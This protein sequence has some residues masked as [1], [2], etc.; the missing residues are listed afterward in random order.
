MQ[1]GLSVLKMEKLKAVRRMRRVKNKKVI[2]R[3]ADRTRQAGKSRNLIA[4]LAIALTAVLFTSVF[5][6]GGSLVN[7]Q[8]QETMRQVG[9]SAQAG[10]KYLTEEEYNIVKQDKKLKEI[11]YRIVVGDA[12]NRELNKLHTE[13]SYYEEL[14]AKFSFCYPEVGRLPEKRDEIVTSDLVLKA[15]GLPCKIGTKVPVTIRIGNKERKEVFTLSGYFKG[16]TIFQAQIMAVS[17]IFANEVAPTP[18]NSAMEKMID[19][20]DYPGRIMA[21]FN[22]RSSFGLKWQ[23]QQLVKRCGFP[24]NIDTGL[25]WAYVGGEI[26][27]EMIVFLGVILLVILV[28]GYLIIYNIFYINVFQDIRYYGILKTIGTTGKQLKKIVRRQ[29]YM[30]SLYGIPLGLLCGVTVGKCILPLI[31][32]QLSFSGTIDTEVSLNI[33]VFI[34]SAAFSFL[35]VYVSCI[36]PCRIA[37]KVSPI[38]AI[39]FT[40]GQEDVGKKRKG[41]KTK[42]VSPGEMALQNIKRNKKKVVIV[43]SSL[44]LALVLLNSIYGLVSGFDMDKYV[45]NMTVSD[46]SVADATVDNVSVFS[47]AKILDGVTK[48]FLEELPKREGVEETGNIYLKELISTF[49]DEDF[50]KIE[51]RILDNPEAEP[52]FRD[53]LGEETDGY[54]TMMKEERWIDGKVYGIGKMIADKLDNLE[55]QIDWK[56]F[57][58]GKYVITGHFGNTEDGNISYF[59]PG[60]TVTLY[61]EKGESREYEVLAEADMPYAC[62]LQSFGV[63][64]CNYI[65]PETEYLDFMGKTQPMRTLFNVK[66]K[67]EKAMEEWMADYCE[68]VNPDLDYTSKMQIVKEF[69]SNKN[70]YTMVGG[71]LA[72]ILAMIGILNFI[73]TMIT[74]VLSRK[75]EFA[76]ME[77]VGMT[78]RQLRSML[79]CEGACY[80]FFTLAVSL[81]LGVIMETTVIRSIGN[82]Y[83]Y[84]TWHLT[85]IPILICIP[86]L[87]MVVFAVPVFCHKNMRRIS[88]VERMRKSE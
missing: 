19:A 33:G 71:L 34:F 65:L 12:I 74:S 77:A 27:T 73:N 84:F 11:S 52:H 15:L 16:D 68:N 47:E 80:A 4:V 13:V 31:M 40:E 57:V 64:E 17:K 60:E 59:K 42:R 8:Q 81:I 55:G 49:T 10:F 36:K 50:S 54:V 86:V 72:F 7:K 85:V 24:D 35:T 41:K 29:A 26:D 39:R 3:I 18:K 5:T 2:R 88:V 22:F 37:S 63:M 53:L 76:M 45:S 30:L 69:E 51:K 78:G 14:D 62:G 28:S 87:C 75:Q 61:N 83:F 70:M 46:F 56:K 20:T 79:C 32:E 82:S 25:N 66:E 21:D 48:D 6:V 9:G 1:T 58:T 67:Q 44:S 23:A 43:V 38:E